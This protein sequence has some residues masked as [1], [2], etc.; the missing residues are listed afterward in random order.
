MQPFEHTLYNIHLSRKENAVF[1]AC[2]D[3]YAFC[4]YVSLRTLCKNS[5]VLAS[6]SD[7]WI[8]SY[9]ISPKHQEILRMIPNTHIFEY[10]FPGSLEQ[11]PQI[12]K[13]TN[14][15]FARYELFTLLQLY[16][17]VLYLDSDVLVQKELFPVCDSL[18]DGIGLIP[19][20]HVQTIGENFLKT[21]PGFNMQAV[22]YN[23]GFIVMNRTGKWFKEVESIRRFLYQYTLEN[24]SALYLPDQG[25]INLAVQ[26]FNILPTPLSVM[27]N[28]PA[29]RPKKKLNQAYI[30]HCTGPRKFWC[31]YYFHDFYK[32]YS[33]W[34]QQGGKPVTIRPKNSKLYQWFID[35]FHLQHHIFIQL[36]PD[37]V[38]SPLK[39]LRFALKKVL[40]YR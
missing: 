40:D 26:K 20:T 38:T 18:K 24:A 11:T 34:V 6:H 9:G 23:S 25:I 31:Y 29:S 7:I 8:A 32:E 15:S 16:K 3:K 36:C 30:V 14:V 4:L 17:N 12:K 5:P 39:A 2:D 35:T 27:Y 28:C 21:I 13:F 33:R 10:E 22:G 37:M 19:D 1:A